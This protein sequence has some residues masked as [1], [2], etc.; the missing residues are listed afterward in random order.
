MS[1]VEQKGAGRLARSGAAPGRARLGLVLV[2]GRGDSARG[3][4]GLAEA[5]ALP[6]LAAVAPEA[7]GNSW[8]PTSFLAPSTQMEPFVGRGL[9]AVEAAVAA[10]EDDGLTRDRIALGGFSQGACLALEYAAR[11][12]GGFHSI[13]GFS[14]GLVGTADAGGAPTEEL[15]GFAPKRFDYRTR[16]TGTPTRLSCHEQDPHIPLA[17]VNE[18]A[19]VFASLGASVSSRVKPGPGH[20]IDDAD[21]ATMRGLLNVA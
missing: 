13:F 1:G 10:L 14:G 12:G 20:G 15:Y 4:L 6:D 17:R 3:I 5:L 19:E 8:W 16:L 2:H 18:T 7:P 11:I 21:L 9:A